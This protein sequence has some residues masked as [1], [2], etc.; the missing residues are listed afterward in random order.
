MS[1]F[2]KGSDRE[3]RFDASL[4]E[5]A[6]EGKPEKLKGEVATVDLAT[7]K[8]KLKSGTG[9][10]VKETEFTVGDSTVIS[11][12]KE[13]ATFE[14]TVVVGRKVNIEHLN[15]IASKINAN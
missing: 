7:K 9:K 6:S 15:G 3:E 4:A 2:G 8:F 5:K 1:A 14:L 12:G 10:A 11:K 13:T